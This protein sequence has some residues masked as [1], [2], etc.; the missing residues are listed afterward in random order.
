MFYF[1]KLYKMQ[2]TYQYIFAEKMRTKIKDIP[3]LI[4]AHK[5]IL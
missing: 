1:E 2:R 5:G 4:A 3:V